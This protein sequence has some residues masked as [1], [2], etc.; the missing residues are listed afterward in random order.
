M[1]VG[2]MVKLG[3]CRKLLLSITLYIN[4]WYTYLQVLLT[5]LAIAIPLICKSTT[6]C[7]VLYT[8]VPSKVPYISVTSEFISADGD[9][10]TLIISWS[11]PF[12]NLY[13]ILSYTILCTSRSRCPAAETVYDET[14][15]T[16]SNLMPGAMYTFSVTATNLIGDGEPATLN[17][18]TVSC[19]LCRSWCLVCTIEF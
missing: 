13:P 19:K 18:T 14:I 5:P 7:S 9:D 2:S 10:V 11:E 12:D 1:A 16:L 3:K 8:A 17:T 15:V 6:A 4:L